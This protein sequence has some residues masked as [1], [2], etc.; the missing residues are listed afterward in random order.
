MAPAGN[1]HDP[2]DSGPKPPRGPLDTI[3]GRC[4]CGAVSFAYDGRPAYLTS[5]N[6]SVC[7]RFGALWAYGNTGSI[8]LQAQPGLS[9]PYIHGDQTLA[10]HHCARCGC[11]THWAALAPEDGIW[12]VAVNM[13][14]AEP[15]IVARLRIRHFDGADSFAYL[16]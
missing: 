13:R 12:R 14:M 1:A 3:R 4:H 15:D 11:L 8:R 16:D 5:C 7:R 9:T 10:F 6:C 2:R